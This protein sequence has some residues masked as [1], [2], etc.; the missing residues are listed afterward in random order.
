MDGAEPSREVTTP[1]K[2]TLAAE[3]GEQTPASGKNGS[4]QNAWAQAIT[5]DAARKLV[6]ER[7]PG[8]NVNSIY[9][10]EDYDD[11]RYLY[12][13]EA[14]FEQTEYEFEID[15]FSGNFLEWSVERKR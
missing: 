8:I 15:P 1:E 14:F 5:I 13:G 12:E 9:I 6:A 4:A 2:T 10:K 3:T 7:I 11:G